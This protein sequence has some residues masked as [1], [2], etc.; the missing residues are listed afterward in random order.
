MGKNHL[1][2]T[3]FTKILSIALCALLSF[4]ACVTSLFATNAENAVA[5]AFG[6]LYY[7]A[8]YKTREESMAAANA[9]CEEIEEEGVTL[10]KNEDNALPLKKGSKISV[11]G[12]ASYGNDSK[13]FNYDGRIQGASASSPWSLDGN[14][15]V[16]FTEALMN[17]GNLQLNPKLM[18]FYDNNSL[19]GEGAVNTWDAKSGETP[20]SSYSKMQGLEDSYS[21]YS[22]AAI[23]VFSRNGGEGSDLARKVQ[24]WGNDGKRADTDHYLQLD[25]NEAELLKYVG[26]RFDKVIVLLNM[27][28]SFECGF[29]DDPNHYGYH[30]NIKAALNIGAPGA[31]GCNGLARILVGDVNPSGRT[32][33]TYARDFKQD[34][35][36]QNFSD[37]SQ[38]NTNSKYN[39]DG[40]ILP[41]K[42]FFNKFVEY[43]EGIYVGYRYWE[44]RGFVE[45]N[46]PYKWED[47]Y[48]NSGATNMGL[49]KVD[50]TYDN[51]YDA[52]VV[53]PFGYGLSY[54]TFS[55][56]IIDVSP[57]K[58]GVLT[59]DGKI[60]V[61]VR[62]TNTGKVAGKEVVQ[63]YNTA[64]YY[65]NGIEKSHVALID[66]AKTTLLQPKEHEDIT[67]TCDV[68]DLASYDYSD[69]NNNGFKGYEV[70]AGTYE[71]KVMK[72][73]HEIWDSVTYTVPREGESGTTGFKYATDE[74]TGYTVENRF[75]E[76][77]FGDQYDGV[78]ESTKA[79][80]M[81]RA[82]FEGTFPTPP[83]ADEHNISDELKRK[84]M[85]WANSSTGD[86]KHTDSVD[87][88]WYND[89]D[90]TFG[91][92]N[93]IKL[94]DLVGLDYDDPLWEKFLDQLVIETSES[95][96][97]NASWDSKGVVNFL[98]SCNWR[99]PAYEAL[100][101]PSTRNPDGPTG[102]KNNTGLSGTQN[103]CAVYPNS[104]ILASAYNKDLAYAMGVAMGNEGLFGDDD[105]DMIN[106][107][108][109]PGANI[110]RSQFSGRNF[111]YCSEDPIVTGY[112]AGNIVAGGRS[113][114]LV[115]YVKH[116]ALND[117]ETYRS[118]VNVWANE[119]SMREI[120]LKAFEIIVKD[121]GAIGIMSS[122]NRIGTTWAGGN[123]NLLTEVLRNEWGFK[124]AVVT[125]YMNSRQEV[126]NIDQAIRTGGDSFLFNV[127]ARWFNNLDS[128]TTKL[129]L[130]K[131]AHN[132]CYAIANSNAMNQTVEGYDKRNAP[133]VDVM[134]YTDFTMKPAKLNVNYSGSVANATFKDVAGYEIPDN[135]KA[136]YELKKGS[137]LPAGLTLNQDG[138]VVG[139]PEVM[140]TFTFEVVAR[141][142]VASEVATVTLTVADGNSLVFDAKALPTAFIGQELNVSLAT[143]KPFVGDGEEQPTDVEIKY[144][145]KN[146]S[147]LPE[148]LNL[149]S[150]G[151]LSGTPKKVCKNYGFTV[152][153]SADGY[154]NGEY[155]FKLSIL[156]KIDF[157]VKSLKDGKYNVP[158]IDC[159]AEAT[160]QDGRAVTFELKDPS[161]MPAGLTLTAGGY[162]TGTP[163]EAVTNRE[164]VIVAKSPYCQP[165]EITYTLT[166][167]IGYT[168]TELL[169]G[170]AGTA[171]DFDL[172]LAMGPLN[173]T[174]SLADGCILPEGL[175]L[176]EEGMLEGTPT[177]A[178]VYTFTVVAKCEGYISDSIT[179]Q[180]YIE[181]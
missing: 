39:D 178:G 56:K 160:A 66:Y 74:V 15:R 117:Q 131:S 129:A 100:G 10:L 159:L 71:L 176:S 76:V 114:G 62:V 28:T 3:L 148:G 111:E 18:E 80:Y 17:V 38:N 94:K 37:N 21:E 118:A 2:N 97:K 63:L 35:T 136:T 26:D 138:T 33:D 84:I 92:N 152:V 126:M 48:Y 91:A 125:D 49:S 145:L 158:Y 137:R 89:E 171:Y 11:F 59:A 34:P 70:E 132:L 161:Q 45:G 95:D 7:A 87:E 101:I 112:T 179:V 107:G 133:V 86:M 96:L 110:H 55:Q 65:E 113:K 177:K 98:R 58:Q 78:N 124:G 53:Y 130:R 24:S 127:G 108:Y 119:Q 27:G 116:F 73:S 90:V 99:S 153:A 44:T 109:S 8:D 77:S 128:N 147:A 12:K 122:F 106:G 57:A 163:D 81:S 151:I 123:Y 9:L 36:Y 13:R 19:S 140:G 175:T 157:K 156:G 75:D 181:A 32:I 180:L 149:S 139:A 43:E 93:G 5:P 172:A 16:T 14:R 68:R 166:I 50:V 6:K 162:I 82:D 64:P 79:K 121:G 51:W 83:T 169:S 141:Y 134:N 72:N 168:E 103:V 67:I 46:T 52:H 54:T 174:Y 154:S 150:E 47:A 42:D 40:S 170:K 85:D 61:T 23:V 1:K 142:G 25:K 155:T 102:F 41:D 88:P 120:Y 60:S 29:L 115:Q 20:V 146:G 173:I 167:G 165:V 144:S 22:E 164:I 104:T 31:K 30:E 105:G 135:A 69:A 4:G 143:A